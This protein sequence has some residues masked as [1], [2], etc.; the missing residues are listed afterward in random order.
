MA[1]TATGYASTIYP[2]TPTIDP[3]DSITRVRRDCSACRAQRRREE[4]DLME[5]APCDC[6]RDSRS[7]RHHRSREPR[8]RTAQPFFTDSSSDEDD[9]DIPYLSRSGKHRSRRRESGLRHLAE[10]DFAQQSRQHSS[11][12][13]RRNA[14]RAPRLP[15]LAQLSF[16]SQG[17]RATSEPFLDDLMRSNAAHKRHRS[18]EEGDVKTVTSHPRKSSPV[19]Y[20]YLEDES[21]LLQP[22]DLPIDN[23]NLRDHLEDYEPSVR[24]RARSSVVGKDTRFGSARM[25]EN[26]SQY[27]QP[28]SPHAFHAVPKD[29]SHS[30]DRNDVRP[31]VPQ[32]LRRAP[33]FQRY[34]DN[35]PEEE[36]P[37]YRNM[38]QEHNLGETNPL[39]SRRHSPS[40]MHRHLYTGNQPATLTTQSKLHPSFPAA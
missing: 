24:R 8:T 37:Q 29:R 12:S 7:R 31:A 6:H 28:Q 25:A 18:R 2:D 19:R 1:P 30:R 36:S 13:G 11:R 32:H 9:E 4:A 39:S 15:S 16:D 38:Q 14:S 20:R 23:L 5:E 21:H 33:S 40:R 26:E 17:P 27:L 22:D 10:P 3:R 34:V 35:Q